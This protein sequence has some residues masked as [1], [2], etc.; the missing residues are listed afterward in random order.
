MIQ[1]L[2]LAAACLVAQIQS[3][4]IDGQQQKPWDGLSN[5]LSD[6][7]WS[8]KCDGQF[9]YEVHEGGD[10]VVHDEPD[11]VIAGFIKSNATEC[12]EECFKCGYCKHAIF[13]TAD[14][15][16]ILYKYNTPQTSKC[17]WDENKKRTSNSGKLMVTC[18]YCISPDR[19][20]TWSG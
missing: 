17:T 11:A 12:A 2:F 18:I 13:N 15:N 9:S 7:Y 5:K 19:T 20:F 6:V 4:A 16:C 10:Q 3:A 14:Q 8:H 1:I